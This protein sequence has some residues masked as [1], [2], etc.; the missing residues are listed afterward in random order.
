LRRILQFKAAGVLCA[1]ANVKDDPLL[2]SEQQLLE[3]ADLIV[4]G[5]PHTRYRKLA[6]KK[7]LVDIWNTQGHGTKV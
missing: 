1:D 2:V 3:D 5:A 4:I 6:T 7:P